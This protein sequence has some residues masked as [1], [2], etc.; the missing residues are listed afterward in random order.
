MSKT[1]GLPGARLGWVITKDPDLYQK[2]AAFKDYTS[3]CSSAPSEILS[4]IVLRNKDVV[5]KKHL[6]RISYNLSLLD[7]LVKGSLEHI[8][9]SWLIEIYTYGHVD[10]II[11]YSDIIDY[12]NE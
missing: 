10:Y 5:I 2:M 1:F 12:I 3:I 8:L 6:T 4:L 7:D 11:D 9:D